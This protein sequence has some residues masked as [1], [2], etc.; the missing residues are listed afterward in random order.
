MLTHGIPFNINARKYIPII[1]FLSFLMLPPLIQADDNVLEKVKIKALE[2]NITAQ[3]Q[4]GG[5]YYN[6]NKT[7]RNYREAVK[8]YKKA[9]KNGY[10]YAQYS[11]GWMYQRGEGV[12]QDK[13]E[14]EILR[15]HPQLKHI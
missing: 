6:G 7:K 8:W 2:G 12:K 3:S 10:V 13:V 5:M 11:L 4:L 1:C 9:A 15:N 14:T